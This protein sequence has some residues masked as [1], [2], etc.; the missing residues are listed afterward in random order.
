MVSLIKEVLDLINWEN[1]L[2]LALLK[3]KLRRMNELLDV[4]R[5]IE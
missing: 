1:K 2:Q 4:L 3:L 5:L